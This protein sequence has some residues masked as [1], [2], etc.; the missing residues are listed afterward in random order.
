M[1]VAVAPSEVGRSG[2]VH[3]D[4]D[5][6]HFLVNRDAYRSPAVFEKEMARLLDAMGSHH[7]RRRNARV[8]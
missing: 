5:Q 3:L 4:A 2:L 7:E 6:T 1:N 8:R